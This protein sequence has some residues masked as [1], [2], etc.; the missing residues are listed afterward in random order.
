VIYAEADRSPASRIAT[1]ATTWE[2]EYVDVREDRA[3]IFGDLGPDMKEFVYKVRAV[4][5]GT[6][7]V[8]PVYGESMYDRTVQARGLGGKITVEGK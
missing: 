7:T 6:F 3:L 8:P 1:P 2:T 4:N 5:K